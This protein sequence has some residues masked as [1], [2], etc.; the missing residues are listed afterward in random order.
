MKKATPVVEKKV[1]KAVQPRNYVSMRQSDKRN[2]ILLG[3]NLQ[4]TSSY[5]KEI[6]K[7]L[8]T[9]DLPRAMMEY[10]VKPNRAVN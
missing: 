7:F 2:L 6:R 9:P 3:K 8:C 10:D 4:G 5:P 1:K